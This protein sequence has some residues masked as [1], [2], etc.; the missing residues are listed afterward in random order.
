M[1]T[2]T[3]HDATVRTSTRVDGPPASAI[4]DAVEKDAALERIQQ[5]ASELR[6]AATARDEAVAIAMAQGCT[7]AEIGAALGV[8]AQAAHRRFRWH[9]LDPDQAEFWVEPP[10]PL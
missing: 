3:Q 8:S 4:V 1:E 10:L 6:K 2:I 9:R 5:T 7:W